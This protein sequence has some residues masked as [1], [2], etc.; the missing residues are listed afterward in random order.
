ML[1][2]AL[3]EAGIGL[4]LGQGAAH[5]DTL[6]TFSGEV[7]RP[8]D[9]LETLKAKAL[10]AHAEAQDVQ[11]IVVSEGAFGPHPEVPFMALDR[12]WVA[13]YDRHADVLVTG[14]ASST[15]TNFG[16]ITTRHWA[17]VLTFLHQHTEP[18]AHLAAEH[19]F[20][21]ILSYVKAGST[22]YQKGL[23]G[24]AE[25]EA[26]WQEV[27]N[28]STEPITVSTDMRAHQN[29]ARAVV[30][31]QAAHDLAKVLIQHCPVCEAWGWHLQQ[32]VPGLRC[33]WCMQPTALPKAELWSCHY[34]HYTEE[35]PTQQAAQGIWADPMYC[36]FC[37]A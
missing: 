29:P 37:N 20:G 34:C 31:T 30:I 21:F 4:V 28:A 18:W 10:L 36:Q 15:E 33:G 25:V 24:R 2:P 11:F 13:L 35:K 17:D 12:E 27:I 3:A 9:V 23:Q 22:Q 14:F 5:T 26:A 7:E 8:G 32:N 1:A 16:S 6:G 19:D